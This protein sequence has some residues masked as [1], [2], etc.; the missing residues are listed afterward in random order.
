MD[1]SINDDALRTKLGQM[2]AAGLKTDWETR[3]CTSQQVN[4][5][6]ARLQDLKAD[7]YEQKLVIAGFTLEPYGD[8][9]L[10]QSCET[11][12]YYLL[13]RKYCELPEL[14]VPVE[15]QWSCIL[16]RV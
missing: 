15:P 11:C 3:A 12:M 16:W 1:N 5:T 4:E 8:E 2:M 10:S 14:T 6:V 13:H 9:E 7:D